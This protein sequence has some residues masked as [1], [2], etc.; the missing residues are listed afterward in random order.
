MDSLFLLAFLLLLTNIPAF[1]SVNAVTSPSQLGIQQKMPLTFLFANNEFEF[2]PLKVNWDG[3]SQNKGTLLHVFLG[4]FASILDIQPTSGEVSDEDFAKKLN[5]TAKELLHFFQEPS[6]HPFLFERFLN[7]ENQKFIQQNHQK[8]K[9][10]FISFKKYI[11]EMARGSSLTCNPGICTFEGFTPSKGETYTDLLIYF[12]AIS[13][14]KPPTAWSPNMLKECN[15]SPKCIAEA[16][17]KAR[18]TKEM[19]KS[20]DSDL[21][22]DKEGNMAIRGFQAGPSYMSIMNFQEF[23]FH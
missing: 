6:V 13:I 7:A 12:T 19:E 18:P 8:F 3:I 9:E 21:N 11:T 1:H 22:G 23:P 16:I 17:K 15:S 2:G 14:D 20:N 4:Y 10:Y 5:S